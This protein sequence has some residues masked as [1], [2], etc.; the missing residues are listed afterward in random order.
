MDLKSYSHWYDYSKARD[1]MFA[2]TDTHFAP[3]Y[4]A[5]ADDKKRLRLN[6]INHILSQIAYEELPREKVKLPRRQKANGYTEP[7]FPFKYVPE[8]F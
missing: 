2:A 8:R 5:N 4:V 1:E 6:I 3:W 7:G